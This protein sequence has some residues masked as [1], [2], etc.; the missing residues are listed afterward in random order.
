MLE[1]TCLWKKPNGSVCKNSR[2]AESSG[3]QCLGYPISHPI[4]LLLG[5][6]SP[7]S[8]FLSASSRAWPL[9]KHL[10]ECAVGEIRWSRQA[11]CSQAGPLASGQAQPILSQGTGTPDFTS[12]N[13]TGSAPWSCQESGAQASHMVYIYNFLG[14]DYRPNVTFTANFLSI[15]CCSSSAKWIRRQTGALKFKNATDYGANRSWME[16]EGQGAKM[17]NRG[18]EKICYSVGCFCNNG[19]ISYWPYEAL[20]RQLCWVCF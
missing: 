13:S 3:K 14:L 19:S 6:P 16:E 20:S 10:I 7:C 9:K 15:R 5:L 12:W 1:L 11:L 17:E 8:N 4:A 18:G 2:P